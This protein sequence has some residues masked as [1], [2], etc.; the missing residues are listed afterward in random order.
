MESDCWVVGVFDAAVAQRQ[1]TKIVSIEQLPSEK[2]QQITVGD[3]SQWSI[4]VGTSGTP[5]GFPL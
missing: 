5:S 3:R 2:G 1:R 4:G